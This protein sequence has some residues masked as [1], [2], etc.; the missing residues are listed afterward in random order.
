MFVRKQFEYNLPKKNVASEKSFFHLSISLSYLEFD[1]KILYR[2]KANIFNFFMIQN[3]FVFWREFELWF[4]TKIV[5]FLPYQKISFLHLISK[6]IF[7]WKVL[8]LLFCKKVFGKKYL[9]WWWYNGL[10]MTSFLEQ[11]ISLIL[12]RI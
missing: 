4:W 2:S 10:D 3:F 5:Y 6:N 7:L 11:W 12:L 8:A 9:H 1:C